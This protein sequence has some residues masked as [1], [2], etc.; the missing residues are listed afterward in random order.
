[1]NSP[2]FDHEAY[3]HF[4]NGQLLEK[5]NSQILSDDAEQSLVSR[6]RGGPVYT[7]AVHFSVTNLLQSTC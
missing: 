7:W 2:D 4:Q 3:Y 5:S 6:E 1:M